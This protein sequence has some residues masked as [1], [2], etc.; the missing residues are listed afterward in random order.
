MNDERKCDNNRFLMSSSVI[1]FIAGHSGPLQNLGN[2]THFGQ[3]C[4]DKGSYGRN[5]AKWGIL[6]E[7]AM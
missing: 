6:G 7:I 5:S 2:F 4:D 3:K 1:L